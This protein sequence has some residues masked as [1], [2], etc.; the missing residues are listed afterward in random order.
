MEK[1]K[2]RKLAGAP[3]LGINRL[4]KEYKQMLNSK[5]VKNIFAYPDE[6]NIFNWKYIIYDLID[7]PY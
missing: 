7:S 3:V 5:T 6:S 1:S 4:Q 2:N